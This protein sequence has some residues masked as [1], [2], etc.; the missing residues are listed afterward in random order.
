MANCNYYGTDGT[1]GNIEYTAPQF[2]ALYGI[3]FNIKWYNVIFNNMPDMYRPYNDGTG[4]KRLKLFRFIQVI[5]SQLVSFYEYTFL[6]NRSDEIYLSRVNNTT[7]VLEKYLRDKFN[8]CSIYLTNN[9]KGTDLTYL[10]RADEFG[11]AEGKQYWFGEGETNPDQTY[12]YNYSETV[13]SEDLTLHIPSYLITNNITSIQELNSIL[14]QYI[15]V[16]NT[17]DIVQF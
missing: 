8:D 7:I 17:W 15:N 6:K 9:Y 10:Y 3:D 5:A 13:S 16:M 11:N 14:D 1:S 2:S 4:F 12:L